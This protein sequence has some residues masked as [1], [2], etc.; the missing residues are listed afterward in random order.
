MCVCVCVLYSLLYVMRLAN[1][2]LKKEVDF[3]RLKVSLGKFYASHLQRPK[4]SHDK[5]FLARV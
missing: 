1:L 3:P 5:T 4:K 2:S